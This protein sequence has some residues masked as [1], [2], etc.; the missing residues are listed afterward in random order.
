MVSVVDNADMFAIAFVIGIFA[1]C[2]LG[3]F[4][5]KDSRHDEPG[6]HHPTISSS[7]VWRR[8]RLTSERRRFS[9]RRCSR[10][11]AVGEV[12]RR[13]RRGFAAAVTWSTILWVASSRFRA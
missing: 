5:G 12:G 4:Y 1:L 6:R 8:S 9:S 7:L 11:A 10:E 2:I 13:F 3:A